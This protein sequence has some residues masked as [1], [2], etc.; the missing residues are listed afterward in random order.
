MAVVLIRACILYVI[1]TFSLRLMGKR[2]LGELQPSELVVTILISNIA[3][4]PVEDSSMPML[5]GVVPIITLVCLDVIMSAVMLK[6]P[7][8]RRLMIGSPRV[9]MSEGVI[10]QKEMK[11]LRYTVDDLV[12][13][14]HE[15]QIFDITQVY[16]A[17][18]E[19]TGKIHFLKK[20]DYQSAEKAD[21]ACGGSS[22]DPPAVIIRDGREDPEQ[23][24]FMGLGMGW[25][26]EQLRQL[27]GGKIAVRHQPEGHGGVLKFHPRAVRF[28]LGGDARER[29]RRADGH[30][31]RAVRPADAVQ[32]KVK[33]HVV[34]VY[35]SVRRVAAAACLQKLRAQAQRL[36]PRAVRRAAGCQDQHTD[37]C[38]KKQ[39]PSAAQR[40]TRSS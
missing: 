38:Q 23:M 11:R 20:K 27:H 39:S 13:A 34:I 22:D 15:E 4:V 17:I 30:L 3:S 18:V 37:R 7:K 6:F 25:L 21:V 24:K 32:G 16:Y 29:L 35:G 31:R 5:M 19:T 1:I 12:E 14:M 28:Q 33:A 8:F 40:I 9:I 36:L 2:Q 26:H 10:M